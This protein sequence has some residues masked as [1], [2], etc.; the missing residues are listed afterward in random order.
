MKIQIKS[1]LKQY[2]SLLALL[3]SLWLPWETTSFQL[4]LGGQTNL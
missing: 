3:T 2:V 4:W 1:L